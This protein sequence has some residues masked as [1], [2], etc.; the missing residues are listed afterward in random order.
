MKCFFGVE[1]GLKYAMTCMSCQIAF[2][3]TWP[4]DSGLEASVFGL[5]L[6]PDDEPPDDEKRRRQTC[7]NMEWHGNLKSGWVVQIYIYI[8]IFVYTYRMYIYCVST[9]F[10]V[11]LGIQHFSRERLSAGFFQ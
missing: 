9:C 5:R 6:P 4:F 3:K 8:Y 7:K 2:A 1:L 11:I 10:N